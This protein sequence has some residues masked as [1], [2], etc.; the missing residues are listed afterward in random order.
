MI[1]QTAKFVYPINI[2]NRIEL[3]IQKCMGE[4]S[5]KRNMLG[6]STHLIKSYI[7]SAVGAHLSASDGTRL[8]PR[9]L[10]VQVILHTFQHHQRFFFEF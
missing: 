2:A 7:R 5:A 8:I 10:L 9:R 4:E 6:Y 1:G 3:I